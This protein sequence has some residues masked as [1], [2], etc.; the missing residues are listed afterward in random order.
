MNENRE[1]PEWNLQLPEEIQYKS[2]T[3]QS[4]GRIRDGQFLYYVPKRMKPEAVRRV[5]DAMRP[6]LQKRLADALSYMDYFTHNP[7][8]VIEAGGLRQL[9]ETIYTRK[10]PE[11]DFPFMINFRRQKTVMGT[12]RRNSAGQVTIHINDYFKGAPLPLL[13]YII[14]HELSHHHC[15]GHDQAFYQELS[16]LCP[17]Y[18]KKRELANAFLLL[19]EAHLSSY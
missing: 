9:A 8:Q 19:R 12:Y 7:S 2:S 6:R 13:E 4:S 1:R 11:I 18:A 10:Y 5:L 17:E 3:R 16:Q 14:A 15:P